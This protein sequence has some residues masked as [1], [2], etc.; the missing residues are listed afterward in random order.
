MFDGDGKAIG[1]ISADRPQFG[2]SETGT[3]ITLAVRFDVHPWVAAELEPNSDP[4]DAIANPVLKSFVAS[5]VAQTTDVPAGV[6]EYPDPSDPSDDPSNHWFE[7][8]LTAMLRVIDTIRGTLDPSVTTQDRKV[9]LLGEPIVLMAA[10]VS[11]EGTE[12]TN[13][14]ELKKDPAPLAAQPPLPM[15][16]VRIGDV[17]RPD[18]GVLGLFVPPPPGETPAA[19]R[20][21]PPSKEAAE[22]AL[23]NGLSEGVAS[24]FPEGL[25]ALH[26][27][28]HDQVSEFEIEPNEQRDIYI[29]ADM[30]GGLYATCGVLPRKKI[31]I[32]KECIDA[33][34]RNLEPTFPVGPVMTFRRAG[35]VR[36]IVPPPRIEGLVG[37]FV[38]AEPTTNGTGETFPEAAVPPVPPVAELP[39]D[40]VVLDEG[41]MRMFKPPQT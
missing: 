26:P 14:T 19:G 41:W 34:L 3:P 2:S 40:R 5:V 33:A 22:K 6:S 36:P 13:L 1:Q 4:L 38:H 29:L 32:P 25:A 23:L 28:V 30:R 37:R 9:R 16:P 17:I 21:A 18:D 10:R 39:E 12:T 35:T 20:F 11:L 7:T 31:T 15:V 8:G 24:D 27:F